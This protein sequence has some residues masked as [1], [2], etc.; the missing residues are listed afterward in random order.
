MC[1]HCLEPRVD[2]VNDKCLFMATSFSPVVYR[3]I[4]DLNPEDEVEHP[5]WR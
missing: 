3:A 2:H 1:G 5:P 4:V